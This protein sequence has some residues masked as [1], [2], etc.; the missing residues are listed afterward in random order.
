MF[1]EDL[2]ENVPVKI[3]VYKNK[4][5]KILQQKT[6]NSPKI[7]FFTNIPMAL[8]NTS[9]QFLIKLATCDIHTEYHVLVSESLSSDVHIL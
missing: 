1:C 5:S 7:Y 3:H 9:S 4:N 6:A 8:T 2:A